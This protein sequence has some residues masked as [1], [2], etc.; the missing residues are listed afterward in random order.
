MSTR[1]RPDVVGWRRECDAQVKTQRKYHSY[2]R[3]SRGQDTFAVAPSRNQ[4][5]DGNRELANQYDHWCSAEKRRCELRRCD[6][7][8]QVRGKD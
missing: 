3:A 5:G 6:I 1:K 2:L 4:Q 8:G 7:I